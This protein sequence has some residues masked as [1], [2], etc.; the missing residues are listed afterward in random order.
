MWLVASAQE[1]VRLLPLLWDVGRPSRQRVRIPTLSHKRLK[2]RRSSNNSS[3]R[4]Q[5]LLR[6]PIPRRCHLSPHR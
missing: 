5:Q 4:R 2:R 1:H 3:R 6:H